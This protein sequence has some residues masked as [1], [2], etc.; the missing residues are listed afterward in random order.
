MDTSDSFSEECDLSNKLTIYFHVVQE[1]T[2]YLCYICN[3]TTSYKHW[4]DQ[5]TE[6]PEGLA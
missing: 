5:M 2:L 1:W 6:S 4:P 3:M